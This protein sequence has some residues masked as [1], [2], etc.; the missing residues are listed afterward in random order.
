MS[1][2]MIRVLL[3]LRAVCISLAIVTANSS[4]AQSYP[5]KPI[6]MIVPIVGSAN[7]IVVR[8]FAPRL[9]TSLGQQVVID[10]RGGGGGV[11]AAIAV[12]KAPADGHVLLLYGPPIWLLPLIR[13]NLPYDPVKDFSPISKV[14]S[15]PT[16]LVVHPSLPVKSVKELISLAKARPGQING[17]ISIAAS[18]HL[19]LELFKSM[20]GVNIA[21]IE[22]KGVGLIITALISG[23]VDLALPALPAAMPHI[24]SGRLRALAIATTHPSDLMPGLATLADSGLPGYESVAMSAL[25]APV[26]TPIAIVK[27][28]N[29]EIE[30]ILKIPDVRDFVAKLGA[31][32]VGGSPDALATA[33]KSEMVKWGKVIKDAGI[34]D[35]QR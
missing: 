16:V 25:F 21:N 1:K 12:A 20:A 23:E 28:L 2:M 5:T 7:D 8:F 15:F 10:N 34:G 30:K 27:R 18:T 19:A 26:G 14:V 29:Q 31:E 6:R 4:I 9:S 32:P 13:A 22:Y 24:E 17:G 35:L 11:P 3:F 33:M